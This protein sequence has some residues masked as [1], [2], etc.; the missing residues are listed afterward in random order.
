MTDGHVYAVASGKGGV[1][2][3]TTA[4]NLGAAVVE[5]DRTVVVVDVDLGMANLANILSVSV[6]AVTLHDVLAGEGSIEDAIVEAPGGFDALLGST[7]VEAFGRADPS[8]LSDVVSA[9]RERYDVVILDGGGGLSHDVTVP[10]GLADGVILVTSPTDAAI[11]NAE[12]TRA[13][14]DRLGG[15]VEGVIVTR[16]GGD[17]TATPETVGD[18][19][20]LPILGAVP[21]DGAIRMSTEEGTPLV[22]VDRENPAAQS[23]REIAYGLLGEPL[24]RD[25]ADEGDAAGAFA[26]DRTAEEP[27]TEA[28]PEPAD[29]DPGG[30]EEMGEHPGEGIADTIESMEST[31]ETESTPSLDPSKGETDED[32][33]AQKS[34]LSRLFGGLF[35]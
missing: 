28:A 14:V 5:A 15:T 1:G 31:D 26:H 25:W 6:P 2:K 16:L 35:G 24:P 29:Q 30:A 8:G 22:A 7:D 9:L 33:E 20:D 3:T 12:K 13:L 17:G 34:F 19:L 10:L 18:R 23:Y 27:T 21:E 4:V 11:A 32:E